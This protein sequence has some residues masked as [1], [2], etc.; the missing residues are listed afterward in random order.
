METSAPPAWRTRPT[1]PH[2]RRERDHPHH[3]RGDQR[4]RMP[5]GA[6]MIAA[7]H[8]RVSARWARRQRARMLAQHYAKRPPQRQADAQHTYH[9]TWRLALAAIAL[10]A[11]AAF[12]LAGPR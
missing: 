2:E 3:R 10:A 7:L 8:A 6:G 12:L 1:V 5:H 4:A 9:R 11:V